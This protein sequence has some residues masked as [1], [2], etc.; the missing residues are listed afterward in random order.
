LHLR[1]QYRGPDLADSRDFA[2]F[3]AHEGGEMTVSPVL[4]EVWRGDFLECV[5][6]GAAVICDPSGDVVHAW[7]DLARVILPRSSSKML[8]ALPLVES[9]AADAAGLTTEH[10]ALACASHNGAAIHTDRVARWLADLG[11]GEADLMCGPQVPGDAEAA[12]ALRAAGAPPCQIHNNC[13]GKHTGFLTLGRHLRAGPAYIEPDHPVQAAVRE[14]IYAMTGDDAGLG[15]AIDGCSAPNFAM[16][17]TGMATAMARMAAPATLGGVRAEAAGRLV[18]A[19]ARH[20]ELVAGE[21][22]AGTDLMRAMKGAAVVKT[23]AE[24][25]FAGILPGR[26][27]G[28]ALKIDDGAT[29][30]SECAATALL[31]RLGVADPDDPMV[32]KRLA[33][34]QR[35]RRD[36][37]TGRI[38][39]AADLWSPGSSKI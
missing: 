17:L 4:A 7:G 10:L 24:G 19:M 21:G 11:L 37:P 13:S 35:N 32:A 30:A 3:I 28:F 20:P 9:G 22:R 18:A 31:V 12:E 29:R 39:P 23:G 16:T 1:R 36:V 15:H 34:P 25:V 33:A 27:L 38:V 5:H 2:E 8:Q 26:G 14:A 6:R